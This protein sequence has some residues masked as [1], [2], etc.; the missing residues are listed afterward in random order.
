MAF[1]SATTAIHEPHYL[2]AH[3]GDSVV[4]VVVSVAVFSIMGTI[5]LFLGDELFQRRL[6]RCSS[7]ANVAYVGPNRE[8]DGRTDVRSV[9]EFGVRDRDPTCC[10]QN[11]D[12][13]RIGREGEMTGRN[14][15]PSL[16]G[17]GGKASDDN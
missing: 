7:A 2:L 5:L 15:R 4:G 3:V 12:L 13:I 9:G 6:W 1:R 17:G 14:R 16:F 8:C 10:C 11:S